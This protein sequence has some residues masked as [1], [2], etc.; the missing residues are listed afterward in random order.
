MIAIGMLI[1]AFPTALREGK[2]GRWWHDFRRAREVSFAWRDPLPAFGQFLQ[3][4]QVM[5]IARAHRISFLEAT[6]VDIE[7][8]GHA[9]ELLL[10]APS[11]GEVS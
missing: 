4:L 6:T 3:V 7:W 5:R 10:C 8:D 1:Y 2:L 9:P 11:A